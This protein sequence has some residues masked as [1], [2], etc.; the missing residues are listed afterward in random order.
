[1]QTSRLETLAE[2]PEIVEQVKAEA[3]ENDDLP[4]RTEVLKRVKNLQREKE[5]ISVKQKIENK[6]ITGLYDVI[7]IDP[8]WPYG[9]EYDPETSRVANPYPE[10]SLTEIAN[11]KLPLESTSVVFLWTTHAFLKNAF[12]L[13]EDWGLTY[14]ATIVWDKEK[15]GMGATIRMQCEFCLLAVK[16]KPLLQ[17]ASIRDI[18]R[19]PRREHSRKPIAFYELVEKLTVGAKLDYFGRTKRDGWDIYGAEVGKF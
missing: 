15:M 12:D 19:E 11:I 13:L 2:H 6:P 7:A 9:R 10:M 8:P 1:M 18:I 14:K 5:I 4:T 3:I 17:G 16:G